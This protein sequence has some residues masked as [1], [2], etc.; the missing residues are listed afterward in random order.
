MNITS[1][2]KFLMLSKFLVLPLVVIL[3]A[4]GGDKTEENQEKNVPF[5]KDTTIESRD[6]TV[7]Y[8]I[9]GVLLP[10]ESASLSPEQ[11]GKIVYLSVD[12]GDRV[13]KGQVI[14]R[15]N[16]QLDYAS[17]QQAVAN[18]NLA[19]SEY[20]RTERLF[21]NGVATEQQFTNA[22]LN[23]DIAET[24]VE[25]ARSKLPLT[26]VRSPINGIVNAKNMS[27][28][29][30]SAPGTP[31][32]EIVDVSRVKV[33]VGIPERYMTDISRGSTVQITFD[34]FP[35]ETYKGTVSFVSPTINENNRTFEV[36][37]VLDNPNQKFKPEMSVNVEVTTQRIPNAIVL[38]QGQIVDY[39][40]EKYVFVNEN[41]IAK[42]RTITLGGRNGNNVQVLSGLNAGDK[43]I[44]EGYQS[45]ADGDEIKVIN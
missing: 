30:L 33:S 32:V 11:G 25:L 3:S 6:F 12:K 10:Y 9:V 1:K 7:S 35:G 38:D 23:L 20:E 45:L 39:G 41:G 21:N 19:L 17:Y 44:F 15:I 5:V 37:V 27:L 36:E 13:R 2:F 22:K 26:V 42:K 34:V 31:I 24:T 16:Q 8:S 29:E 14:A 18:Y 28:G 4:C 40:D 43:L